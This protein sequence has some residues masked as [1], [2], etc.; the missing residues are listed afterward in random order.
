[1]IPFER[2]KNWSL[3]DCLYGDKEKGRKPIAQFQKIIKEY[4]ILA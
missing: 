3:K 2:G 1:M 4:H